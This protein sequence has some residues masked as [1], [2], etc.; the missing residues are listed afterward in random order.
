MPLS[1]R[2]ARRAPTTLL[3]SALLVAL[4]ATACGDDGESDTLDAE[5]LADPTAEQ[6][7][8]DV[9]PET[10][11]VQTDWMPEAEHGPIYNLVGPGYTVNTGNKTITGPLVVDN[12]NT[13]VEIEVRAGGAA[14]S[15][16]NI[17]SQ[18]YLEQ[19]ITLGMVS[20]DGAMNAANDR[21]VTAV[22]ALMDK[23]PQMLMWDPETH[24]DWQTIHDIGESDAKVVYVEGSSY[25]PMLV[26][27]G[28]VREEQLDASY[29]GSPS[30]FVADPSIAQQG[31]ATTE[32]YVYENE[33]SAWGRPVEY[34]LLA[35]VGYSVYPQALSVRS[36]ELDTLEPCLTKLVPLMQQ[37]TVD[38][39]EDP[40]PTVELIA[41]IVTEYDAGWVYSE[42]TGLFGAEQMVELEL[43][44]NGADGSVGSFDMERVDATREKF[45]PI[46]T[47]S[48]A[49]LPEDL[50]AEDL[51]TNDFIDTSVSLR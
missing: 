22:M 37:S 31:Y 16:Q 44:T 1:T 30:R 32:P 40:A 18:M 35:D 45:T 2:R 26:A 14:I 38:F 15:Y 8:S 9:C 3:A 39:A 36:A 6:D 21:P 24:P 50:S 25:A 41:E 17:P 48:G 12:V 51:A 43:L 46:V 7:L 42:E 34:Q 28:L 27:D 10:I 4:T 19:E 23:S 20:T 49:Q 33:V 11:V 29:D 47:A 5:S 13:G